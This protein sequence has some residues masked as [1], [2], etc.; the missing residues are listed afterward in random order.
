MSCLN[1]IP[2]DELIDVIVSNN[3]VEEFI[4][5]VKSIKGDTSE[6]MSLRDVDYELLLNFV[7]NKKLI[8]LDDV[9]EYIKDV[10]SE[11]GIDDS[12]T[13]LEKQSLPKKIRRKT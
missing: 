12:F 11:K 7:L 2:R 13:K 5:W 8:V 6:P 3:M 4:S 10:E 1:Y 9:P